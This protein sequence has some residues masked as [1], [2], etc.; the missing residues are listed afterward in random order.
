MNLLDFLDRRKHVREFHNDI[1]GKELIETVLWKT[2]KVTPS[3][4]NFMPYNIYVLGPDKKAE[5]ESIWR[6]CCSNKKKTNEKETPGHTE[7]GVNPNFAAVKNNPYMLIIS[8]TVRPPNEYYRQM[9]EQ[10]DDF[11]EQMHP[12]CV[13]KVASATSL[14]I[15]MFAANLSA[16]CTEEDLDISY[17]CAIPN[18]LAAWRDMPFLEY[19]PLLLITI[20][21][22]KES[23]Q[24]SYARNGLGKYD[25]KPEFNEVV[26][27]VQ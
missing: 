11:F 27:W 10:F 24:D 21:Y 7:D 14:E 6:K 9:I 13:N 1:P 23:L 18:D 5:K 12:R 26:H 8:Q 17:T 16:F 22:C 19:Q 3:K 20:G 4:N 15:G 2:W 25:K